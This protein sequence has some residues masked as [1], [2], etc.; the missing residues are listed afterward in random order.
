MNQFLIPANSKRGQ[1]LFGLFKGIDLAIFL[2]GVLLTIGLLAFI[3][4]ASST[5]NILFL[6]PGLL[7][8]AL[9]VPIPSYHNVRVCIGEIINFYINNRKYKWRGWCSVYESKRQ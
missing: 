5:A 4:D 9:V 7:A 3:P 1:L 8:I 6:I 2:I